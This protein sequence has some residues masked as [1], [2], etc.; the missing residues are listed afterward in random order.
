MA[1][2]RT[3]FPTRGRGRREFAIAMVAF[4]AAMGI[5]TSAAVAESQRPSKPITVRRPPAWQQRQAKAQK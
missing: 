4:A 1:D 5:G 3:S 2:H